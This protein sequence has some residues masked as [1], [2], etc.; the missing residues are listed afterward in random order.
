MPSLVQIDRSLSL[1]CR[2]QDEPIVQ[3]TKHHDPILV[4]DGGN[5][6]HNPREDLG[7]GCKTEA[8]DPELVRLPCH[9]EAKIT[10]RIVM[11][12]NLQVGVL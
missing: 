9:H 3:V 1:D 5:G 8:E 11:N 7:R 12:W 4:E 10:T 6:S 2:G